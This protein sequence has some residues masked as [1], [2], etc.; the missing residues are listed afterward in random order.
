[1]SF[2]E[3]GGGPVLLR[4]CA[5][6]GGGLVL[7]G[8][9]LGD[10]ALDGRG[11]VLA[12]LGDLVGPGGGRVL[13]PVDARL[14]AETVLVSQRESHFNMFSLDVVPLKKHVYK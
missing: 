9:G 8:L 3:G 1:M 6:G 12:G 14:A 2:V 13:E 4:F 10:L 7:D 5:E 11:H